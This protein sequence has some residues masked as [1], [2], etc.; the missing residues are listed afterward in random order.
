MGKMK[1]REA[2]PIA[3]AETY[4]RYSSCYQIFGGQRG[5][6]C[7]QVDVCR[8]ILLKL[9]TED[10]ALTFVPPTRI[11]GEKTKLEIRNEDHWNFNKS[12]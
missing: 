1:H 6:Q 9:T 3:R 7:R 11:R 12:E 2:I 10:E 8:R 4:F 5:D